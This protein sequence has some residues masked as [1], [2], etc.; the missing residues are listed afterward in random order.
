MEFVIKRAKGSIENHPVEGAYK[1]AFEWNCLDNKGNVTC[2]NSTIE[3][4]IN[5][6]GLKGLLEFSQKHGE[7]IINTDYLNQEIP[8]LTIYDDMIE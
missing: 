2:Y 3:H 6:E 8:C 7:L 4:F 1:R 5:L